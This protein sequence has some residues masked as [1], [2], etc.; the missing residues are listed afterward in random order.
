MKFRDIMQLAE[1]KPKAGQ[2]TVLAETFWEK[3]CHVLYLGARE[4]ILE[5]ISE[6]H[7]KQKGILKR[8]TL[9]LK[10]GAHWQD[11]QGLRRQVRTQ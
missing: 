6:Y 10:P 5:I 7:M 11:L 4:N 1:T 2:A 3:S 9:I 8:H